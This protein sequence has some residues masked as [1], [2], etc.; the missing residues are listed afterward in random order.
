MDT[1]FIANE[2]TV[3]PIA[4]ANG[5]S[6]P[7]YFTDDQ[8]MLKDYFGLGS[9]DQYVSYAF[10]YFTV[11]ADQNAELWIGSDE[12]LKVYLNEQVV[13]NYTGTRTFSGTD[14][15]KDTS[16]ILNLK[17]GVNKL[18]VK[19]YQITGTYNFS[20]NICELSDLGSTPV[21]R[22]NRVAGLKIYNCIP[23][24]TLCSQQRCADYISIR[25]V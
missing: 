5:W 25:T 14:Y 24:L 18:L 11:P 2:A 3:A 12:A 15:Y 7:F 20:L 19:A 21:Y 6:Q 4:G 9:I 13:Y 8:I 16:T 23:W 17:A 10:T 1:Q 22:G